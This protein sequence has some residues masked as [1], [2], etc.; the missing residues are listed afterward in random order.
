[1]PLKCYATPVRLPRHMPRH[2]LHASVMLQLTPRYAT[3]LMRYVFR[4]R[5]IL[6]LPL[7]VA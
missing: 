5:H 4:V 1:M 6:M 3:L 7:S 2:E